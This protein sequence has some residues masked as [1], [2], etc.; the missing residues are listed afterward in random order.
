MFEVYPFGMPRTK[1]LPREKLEQR[2]VQSLSDTDLVSVIIGSGVEG[3]NVSEVARS[4]SRTIS[5]IVS[6]GNNRD[7]NNSREILSWKD[8]LDI[9]GVGKVKAMQIVCALELGRRMFGDAPEKKIVKNRRDVELMFRHLKKRK[10]EHVIVLALN[11]R[12]EIIGSKT[13]AVGSLNKS[14]VEP[15]DIF[16]WALGRHAAG[17]IIV[18]NHPSGDT[19]LSDADKAFT[20]RLNEASALLGIELI[21][22]VVV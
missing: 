7:E 15:R 20:E 1:F 2:G 5:K 17:I 18:H 10:Q 19:D 6:S 4:V 21:D 9:Q 12:S 14:V 8:L 22:H 13:V 11:A 16:S 3:K